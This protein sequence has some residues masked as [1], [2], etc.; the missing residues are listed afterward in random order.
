MIEH[1]KNKE[2]AIAIAHPHPETVLALQQLIPTLAEN[3]IQLVSL[4]SLYRAQ[5]ASKSAVVISE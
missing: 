2:F 1:A 3:N 4:S 5:T